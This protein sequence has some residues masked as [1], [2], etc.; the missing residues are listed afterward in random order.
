M[1]RKIA[2]VIAILMAVLMLTSCGKDKKGEEILGSWNAAKVKVED[3]EVAIEDFMAEL[4]DPAMKKQM[5]ASFTSDGGAKYT[6][7][8]E[9]TEG[10][11][12]ANE[13]GTY[14]LSDENGDMAVAVDGDELILDYAGIQ[15]VF[16][17]VQ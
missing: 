3:A 6:L 1:R 2:T 7:M 16:E 12:E 14:T 17:R 10:I 4:E 9:K 11:W 5:S 15:I 13:D 8:G